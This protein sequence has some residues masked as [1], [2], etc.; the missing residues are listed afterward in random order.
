MLISFAT[1]TTFYGRKQSSDGRDA[2]SEKQELTEC[3][4]VLTA[5]QSI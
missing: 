1:A 4:A 5:R 2:S 3:D